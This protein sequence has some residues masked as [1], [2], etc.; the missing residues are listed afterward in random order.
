MS[1]TEKARAA[2]HI[3]KRRLRREVKF[4]QNYHAQ[5]NEDDAVTRLGLRQGL[6]HVDVLLVVI[7]GMG[8]CWQKSARRSQ[9]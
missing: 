8:D 6:V 2:W 5:R 3:E 4:I 1:R 7:L 9:G